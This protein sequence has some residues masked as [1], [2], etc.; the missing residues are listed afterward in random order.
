MAER[1]PSDDPE[2]PPT[3]PASEEGAEEEEAASTP[4]DNPFFLPLV[5]LGFSVWF[6]Y[7]GWFNPEMEWKRFNQV[8]GVMFVILGLYQG[9]GAL[10]YSHAAALPV[11]LVGFAG[12][13]A[14]DGLVNP[15]G[16]QQAYAYLN[17]A[18]AGGCVL[19]AV[20]RLVRA[21]REEP[22][23]AEASGSGAP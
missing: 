10:G 5:L 20:Y 9:A 12:W 21:R 13:F 17:L 19:L 1:K 6:I 8:L 23:E 3:S 11:I 22:A 4:F 7:D 16:L 14:Y 18:A 2:Q 15:T